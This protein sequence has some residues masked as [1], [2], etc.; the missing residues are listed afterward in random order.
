[1]KGGY[2]AYKRTRKHRHRHRHRDRGLGKGLRKSRGNRTM[3]LKSR[4]R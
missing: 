2:D 1:M 4:K 3:R